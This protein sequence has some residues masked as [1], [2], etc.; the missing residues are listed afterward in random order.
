[1]KIVFKMD[2]SGPVQKLALVRQELQVATRALTDAADEAVAERSA[3]IA[4]VLENLRDAARGVSELGRLLDRLGEP[5]PAQ[6]SC[7]ACHE[8][9]LQTATRCRYC[10]TKMVATLDER[11]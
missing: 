10:W 7:P 2:L 9:I 1:M 5:S 8:M 4:G 11:L 6:R 3:T